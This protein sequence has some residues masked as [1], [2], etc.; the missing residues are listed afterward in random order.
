MAHISELWRFYLLCCLLDLILIEDIDNLLVEMISCI[1]KFI[2]RTAILIRWETL[3]A[4]NCG[5]RLV[6]SWGALAC[7]H[8]ST[9]ETI[10]TLCLSQLSL[11]CLQ[12][13]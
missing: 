12:I 3:E 2:I 7:L 10:L 5:Y 1:E 4:L 8:R 6:L 11:L 9:E 13:E